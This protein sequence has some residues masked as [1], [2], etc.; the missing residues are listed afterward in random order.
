MTCFNFIG[1][2]LRDAFDPRQKKI[3]SERE[4]RKALEREEAAAQRQ[5]ADRARRAKAV[6]D[7]TQTP[8][9]SPLP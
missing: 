5:E 7:L 9:T 8:V 6:D 3:P 2:G 4:M 1:D